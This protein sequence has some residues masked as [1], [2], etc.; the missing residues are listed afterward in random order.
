MEQNTTK[1]ETDMQNF[2]NLYKSFGIKLNNPILNEVDGL[3]VIE[4]DVTVDEKFSGVSYTKSEVYFSKSE[5]FV[6]QAF[7]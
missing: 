4:L 1:T 6:S 7:I 5:R 3:F 2:I